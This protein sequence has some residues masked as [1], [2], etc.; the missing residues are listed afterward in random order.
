MIHWWQD[1]LWQS[2]SQSNEVQNQLPPM[3][4]RVTSSTRDVV[5]LIT[6]LDIVW[7]EEL[8]KVRNTEETKSSYISV[9]NWVIYHRQDD[10]CTSKVAPYG[11]N[12]AEPVQQLCA[13]SSDTMCLSQI[14]EIHQHSGHLGVW[15]TT[16]FVRRIWSSVS[17]SILKLTVGTCAK[18]TT[19]DPVPVLWQK[20]RLRI[21]STWHQLN[22]DIMHYHGSHHLALTDYGP[23]HFSV[24]RPL[25]CQDSSS[26]IHQLESVFYERR[27]PSGLLTDNDTAF[28]NRVSDFCQRKGLYICKS[29]VCMSWQEMEYQRGVL[30]VP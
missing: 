6:S 17:K 28:C 8:G 13:V 9:T 29:D 16:Y 3:I 20:G 22:M 5:V 24:W 30:E 26:I 23:S 19:V 12:G 25:H 15:N 11:P 27:P 21:N 7:V 4:Y 10:L 1:W 14:M 18:C 2:Q